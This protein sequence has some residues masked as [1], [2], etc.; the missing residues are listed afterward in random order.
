MRPLQRGS[1]VTKCDDTLWGGGWDEVEGGGED[2]NTEDY[3]EGLSGRRYEEIVQT[4]VDRSKKEEGKAEKFAE[5]L[6][7]T[8]DM[9]W[10]ETSIVS[11]A[12]VITGMYRSRFS[13]FVLLFT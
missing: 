9:T 1:Y 5:G 3:R 8:M 10:K 12:L 4:I 2:K 11:R 6:H 7:S 13:R